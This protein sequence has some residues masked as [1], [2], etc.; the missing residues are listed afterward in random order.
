VTIGASGAEPASSCGVGGG[1]DDVAARF[2]VLH[3]TLTKRQ[4]AKRQLDKRR[5]DKR[6]A[7]DA[8]LI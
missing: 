6:T 4:L 2:A 8:R 7:A 5:L 3:P 1:A